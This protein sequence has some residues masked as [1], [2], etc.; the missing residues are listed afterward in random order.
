MPSGTFACCARRQSRQRDSPEPDGEDSFLAR[1]PVKRN[2]L[3]FSKRST[4]FG[5]SRRQRGALQCAH[6]TTPAQGAAAP[7]LLILDMLHYALETCQR[8]D[9]AVSR[10]NAHN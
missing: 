6:G 10:A 4:E 7:R 1:D 5:S 2:L 9:S 3:P 8:D